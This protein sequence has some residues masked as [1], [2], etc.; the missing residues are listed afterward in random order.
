MASKKLRHYF[1]VHVINV[2]TNHP[3]KKAMNKL[4]AV[5][6]LIQWAVEH[7]EFDVRYQPRSAIKTQALADFI[8]EFTPSQDELNKE[9]RAQRFGVPRVLVS[10]N[11]RQFDN[12]PF[13]DF[14]KQLGIRNHYFLPS[15]PWANGQAEVANWSLLKIIKTRLEGAKEV[16]P[17]KLLGV[18]WAYRTTGRTPTGETPFKLAYGSKTVIPTEVHMANHRVMKY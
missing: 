12:T 15:H 2:L 1:Q 4:E 8:A 9:E 6:R 17:N 14:C 7:S 11:G 10:D 5:R 3:L 18:L 16:W 13:K